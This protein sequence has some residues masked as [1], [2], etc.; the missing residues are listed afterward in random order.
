MDIEDNIKLVD[1]STGYRLADFN[2]EL[3]VYNSFL[4][5]ESIKLQEVEM[6][7]VHLLINK[8]NADI[9]AY[10]S[11]SA[12]SIKLSFNEKEQ[13][14]I[15]FVSLEYIPAVKIG[16]LA[17][18]FKYSQK[19]KAIGSLMIELAR[20]IVEDMRNSGIACRF[21]TVDADILNNPT[22]DQ[23][24]LKKGFKMNEKYKKTNISMRLDIFRNIDDV[25]NTGTRIS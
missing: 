14:S 11:L 7:K 16:R 12:D 20:G 22:V 21:I 17:I 10:M 23:F 9:I 2:C 3:E 18:D 1:L 6:T 24:Y 5:C 15:D 8:L 4:K 19:Y 25:I 13:H